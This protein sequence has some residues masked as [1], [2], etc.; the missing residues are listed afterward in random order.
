[1]RKF[2]G[3]LYYLIGGAGIIWA[4]QLI[5]SC[6]ILSA[7]RREES[8]QL[9]F[10]DFIL[11]SNGHHGAYSGGYI[12][13]IMRDLFIVGSSIIVIG[14]G[15]EQFVFREDLHKE[16]VHLIICP[17]CG[18]K[19][20]SDAYC[21]FCGFNLITLKLSTDVRPMLPVWQMAVFAYLGISLFMVIVNLLLIKLR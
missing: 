4:L 21:R 11:N 3:S 15:R 14:L 17:H 2:L 20:F 18:K 13:H 19:T 12:I 16:T 10:W 5:L 1:M 9:D 6:E 8:L 7:V